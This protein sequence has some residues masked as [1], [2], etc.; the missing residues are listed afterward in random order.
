MS[1][2]QVD[3]LK[4]VLH[5]QVRLFA[6]RERLIAGTDTEAL[7]DLRIALRQ[8]RSLLRPL[9]GLPACDELSE[10]AAQLGRLSGPVRDLEVLE[11]H[12]REVGLNEAADA[13]LARLQASYAGLIKSRQ[14]TKLFTVLDQWPQQWRESGFEDQVQELSK[15]VNKCLKKDRKRLYSALH[16]LLGDRHRLRLLVKRLRYN[17]EAYA[18]DTCPDTQIQLKRA[19]S[20][21]GDWHDH[22]Q[23]LSRAESEVDLQPRIATWRNNMQ[24]AAKRSDE[25]LARLMSDPLFSAWNG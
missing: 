5:L 14:M 25:A 15:R 4:H 19:Q 6:C 20:A 24:E 10:A 9:R 3:V 13:R 21:L 11:A 18:A 23:W 2:T 8:L 17:I 12:L 1:V 22:Y 16:E 7:H